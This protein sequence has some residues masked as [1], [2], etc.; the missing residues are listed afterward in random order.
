MEVSVIS[1][2]FNVAAY[3][4]E[5]LQSLVDQRFDKPYEIIL[6]EDCSTDESL[7]ICEKWVGKSPDKIKLI[8]NETNRGVSIARS[9]GLDAM[10]GKYFMFVDS[11]DRLPPNAIAD[12]HQ[13]AEQSSADIVKG[14]NTV[15]YPDRETTARFN[16][17]GVHRFSDEEVL[18]ALYRH[19]MVRGHPWGK[20]FRSDTCGSFRFTEGIRMAQ[21]LLYC[22]EVFAN[23]R[24]MVIFDKT[25]YHYR[26]HVE[27]STG[28]KFLIG[29]YQDW[30]ESVEKTGEFAV[31]DRQKLAHLDLV[32][33]N[34]S[35]LARE[36]LKRKPE[37][38]QEVL[39][40]LRQKCQRWGLDITPMLGRG[41]RASAMFRLLRLKSSLRKLAKMA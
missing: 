37:N 30:I 22:S 28:K 27:G 26:N 9:R 17:S 11:D 41:L 4:D 20:F 29:S 2:V 7:K 33:R 6:V 25:V 34:L 8:R 13:M 10:T 23:A 5:C 14:N 19:D 12:L 21:D 39:Q 31:S 18:S 35:I 36:T 15:F 38:I 1:P 24:S 16:V 32:I 40:F 3:L